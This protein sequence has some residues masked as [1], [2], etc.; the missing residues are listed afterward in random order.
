MKILVRR[1]KFCL[2]IIALLLGRKFFGDRDLGLYGSKLEIETLDFFISP[3]SSIKMPIEL[4][5]S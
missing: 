2:N 5:T 4:I 1:V 3:L